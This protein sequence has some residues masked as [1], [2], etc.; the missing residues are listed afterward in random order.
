[1]KLNGHNGHPIDPAP[2]IEP[3]WLATYQGATAVVPGF[4]NRWYLA[5]EEARK[6][7]SKLTKRPVSES[8]IELEWK[9]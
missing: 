1:M 5:R 7:F 3:G 8:E 2:P 9:E 4:E 6:R